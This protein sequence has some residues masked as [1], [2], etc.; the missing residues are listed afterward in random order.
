MSVKS[1]PQLVA[2]LAELDADIE[3]ARR[4]ER[5]AAM[6]TIRELMTTFDIKANE[7]RRDRRGPY[8]TRPV[9]MKYRD[10]VSGREWSGRGHKPAWFTGKDRSRF[11]IDG[12]AD[13]LDAKKRA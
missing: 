11:L 1:Y 12:A 6:E 7:L 5:A 4:R 10:P 8:R 9:E 3:A 2:E 13:S